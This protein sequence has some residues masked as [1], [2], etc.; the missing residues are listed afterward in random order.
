MDQILCTIGEDKLSKDDVIDR[1]CDH[2]KKTCSCTIPRGAVIP[3]CSQWAHE[4]IKLKQ[5]PESQATRKGVKK[6]LER[7]SDEP[8]GESTSFDRNLDETSSEEMVELLLD[9]SNISELEKR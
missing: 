8:C 5:D 7:I 2:I 3:V 4:A 6:L 1:V 9:H